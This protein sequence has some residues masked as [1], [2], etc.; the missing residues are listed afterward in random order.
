MVRV[1]PS[2]HVDA[3]TRARRADIVRRQ[4]PCQRPQ[5]ECRGAIHGRS[6]A[7]VRFAMFS[8]RAGCELDGVEPRRCPPRV[9][10]PAQTC[11]W[12]DALSR[13]RIRQRLAKHDREIDSLPPGANG[14]GAI[15]RRPSVRR[16]GSAR[17]TNA[18][19]GELG[20]FID[21][22][23]GR[24]NARRGNTGDSDVASGD[25]HRHVGIGQ[26]A[27][28]PGVNARRSAHR[29]VV[30]EPSRQRRKVRV[31]DDVQGEAL[32]AGHLFNLSV[33]RDGALGQAHRHCPDVDIGAVPPETS[34]DRLQRRPMIVPFDPA[35]ARGRETSRSVGP[36]EYER[37]ADIGAR[38]RT[39]PAEC[40]IVH[41]RMPDRN[42]RRGGRRRA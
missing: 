22:A 18:Q 15:E 8:L 17:D 38:L 2:A 12:R 29:A 11:R 34:I 20:G 10:R 7:G 32:L 37:R 24:F 16:K 9:D 41:G 33:G 23:H 1:D 25:G 3:R 13:E 4:P 35:R 5:S 30:V 14:A 26:R 31:R 21:N 36:V 6:A 39:L 19:A 28:E 42:A 27:S 40:E